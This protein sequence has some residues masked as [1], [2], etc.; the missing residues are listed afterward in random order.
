[1]FFINSVNCIQSIAFLFMKNTFNQSRKT[2][3][4][5]GFVFSNYRNLNKGNLLLESGKILK[6][7]WH[8][9]T[10]NG[11]LKLTYIKA[12][13]KYLSSI[14]ST[15]CH[16]QHSKAMHQKLK[17][18][19]PFRIQFRIQEMAFKLCTQQ[20]TGRKSQEGKKLKFAPQLNKL[21]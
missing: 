15:S 20:S 14:A 7:K 19:N 9:I 6:Q 1:M 16:F 4:S 13:W 3:H 8:K 10:K 11:M 12:Q 5:R 18:A 21:A 17:F 2:S